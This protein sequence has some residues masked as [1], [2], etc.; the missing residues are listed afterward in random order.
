M[1]D[2]R[3]MNK[4][5]QKAVLDNLPKGKKL[6]VDITG[7]TMEERE[8]VKNVFGLH[9][10]TTEDL[11]N[12]KVR[13]KVEEFPDYLFCVF[14]GI[15]SSFH[16]YELDF[17]IGKDFVITNHKKQAPTFEALRQDEE[18]LAKHFSKGMD[19]LFHTLLDLEIDNYVPVLE[20]LEQKIEHLEDDVTTGPSSKQQEQILQMRKVI[21]RIRKM[22]SQQVEKTGFLAKQKFKQLSPKTVPYFRDIYDH[23]VKVHDI[24]DGH[25]ETILG[26]YDI[27][28]SSLSNKMN[29]VMKTLSIIA[30]IALPLSVISGVYGTNFAVLPGH[31]AP[32][33]FWIMLGGMALLAIAM[34]VYF[35]RK[36]WF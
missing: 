19:F 1:L 12:S 35:I 29:E 30:T 14:Y 32:Y 5:I 7:I 13:I 17:I 18:K 15:D 10:L 16:M 4:G 2:I 36:D 34:I 9:P 22:T 25:R 11:Y 3:Y 6:W 24:M 26:V 31:S 20:K 33:G 27:Y 23:A 28:M 21:S 8:A